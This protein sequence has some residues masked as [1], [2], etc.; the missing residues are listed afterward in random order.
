MK[1]INY[2]YELKYYF[3]YNILI[4]CFILI[5]NFIYFNEIIFI[6][7]KPLLSINN[8][9]IINFNKNYLIFTGLTDI[10]FIYIKIYFII[11]FYIYLPIL[12]L[13][14]NKFLISG[15]Y[16]SEKQFLMY[17][18]FFFF[19][20]FFI[21]NFIIYF[22]FIPK[23]WAFFL[24]FEILSNVK[25]FNLYFEGKINDYLSLIFTLLF[26]INLCLNFPFILIFLNY[27]NIITL[28]IIKKKRKYLYFM[29]LIIA[30]VLTPPDFISL[31][32][33]IILLYLLFEITYFILFLINNYKK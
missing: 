15:L 33:L 14:F 25:L 12:I 19:I 20:L 8:I 23:I 22:V 1:V 28:N 18:T 17:I 6:L 16:F 10:L 5:I 27:K 2:L 9:S 26:N 3:F 11:C 30:S 13:Q 7:L 24:D 4:L 21:N 31:F 32:L 29:L